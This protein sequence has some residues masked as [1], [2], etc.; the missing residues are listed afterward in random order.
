MHG[1]YFK[2][3]L[4]MENRY[5]KKMILN[6]QLISIKTNY[7]FIFSKVPYEKLTLMYLA[8]IHLNSIGGGGVN[9]GHVSVFTS[10]LVNKSR[11]VSKSKVSNILP[12]TYFAIRPDTGN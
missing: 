2:W 1:T 3:Y 7:S 6:L 9:I 4:R 10:L 8:I 11:V 5:F 12:D